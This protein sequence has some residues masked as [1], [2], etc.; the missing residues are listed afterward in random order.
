MVQAGQALFEFVADGAPRLE[1]HPDESHLALIREGQPAL[2]SVEARPELTF[3]A[4]VVRIAPMGCPMELRVRDSS[5]SIRRAEAA[6]VAVQLLP[7][8]GDLRKAAS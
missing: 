4:T 3:P 7:V 5:L 8:S 2:A 6:G 1:V